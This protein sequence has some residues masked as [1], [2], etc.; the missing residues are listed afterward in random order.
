[1]VLTLLHLQTL[2]E[3][4]N[5][6]V[7]KGLLRYDSSFVVMILPRSIPLFFYF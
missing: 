1:M 5:N 4:E 7:N 3:A 2:L 6:E